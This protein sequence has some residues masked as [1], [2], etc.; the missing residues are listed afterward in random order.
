LVPSSRKE[1]SKLAGA[2]ETYP[3]MNRAFTRLVV[4]LSDFV[5]NTIARD[6]GSSQKYLLIIDE[7]DFI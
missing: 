3:V 6:S 4:R 7:A 5:Q 2:E 1:H